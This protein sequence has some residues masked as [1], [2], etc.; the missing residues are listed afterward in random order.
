MAEVNSTDMELGESLG[1]D[2][3]MAPGPAHFTGAESSEV[4]DGSAESDDEKEAAAL[5]LV[6]GVSS[7]AALRWGPEVSLEE[8]EACKVAGALTRLLDAHGGN[9]NLGPEAGFAMVLGSVVV[10]KVK[11]YREANPKTPEPKDGQEPQE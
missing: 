1:A 4:D 2:L 8:A 5:A 3:D 11:S 10:K 9:V 6:E 7:I